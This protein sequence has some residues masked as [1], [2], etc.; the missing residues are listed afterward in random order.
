MSDNYD[1][2]EI[3]NNSCISTINLDIDNSN[4]SLGPLGILSND[5]E[6]N[7]YHLIQI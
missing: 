2:Y 6:A 1:E 5:F 3:K 4:T 7:K